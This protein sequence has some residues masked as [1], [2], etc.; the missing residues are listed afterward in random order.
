M[1]ETWQEMQARHLR[2]RV[3]LEAEERREAQAV[4]YQQRQEQEAAEAR[5]RLADLE[6]RVEAAAADP[7]A[8]ISAIEKAGIHLF[9][10]DGNIVA[11]GGSLNLIQ[12]R[13]IGLC[14]SAVCEILEAKA[15]AQV[16]A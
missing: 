15:V 8:L 4:M 3:A 14:K 7:N 12:L 2:E 10:E 6:R 9:I 13:A 5:Q 16:V 1:R 11:R